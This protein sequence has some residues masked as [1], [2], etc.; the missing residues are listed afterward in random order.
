MSSMPV[1]FVGATY[2]LENR[3]ADVQRTVNMYPVP[4]ESGS[5]KAGYFLR[6]L[7]GYEDY[8]SSTASN[9]QVLKGLYVAE[10]SSA[11]YALFNGSLRLINAGVVGT[12]L[13]VL[14][15]GDF[16]VMTSG[17][18]H[19]VLTTGSAAYAYNFSTTVFAQITSANLEPSPTWCAYLAGRYIFGSANGDQFQWSAQDDP[20]TIDALD[21]ATAESSPD[22]LVRGV[23]YREELW[24]FGQRSIEV[25]RASA[26]PDS[27]FERNSGV[28]IDLGL[29]AAGSVSIV[30]NSL[31]WI[32]ADRN[33]GAVVYSASG[34]A[35]TR[36]SNHA[37]E[38]RLASST[39]IYDATAYC[40]QWKGHPF[41]CLNAPGLDTTLVY[42]IRT[43]LWHERADFFNGEVS[44]HRITHHVYSPLNQHIFGGSL[45]SHPTLSNRSV[46]Y[47]ASDDVYTI[48]GDTLCRERTS[49]HYATPQ[50]NRI[51]YERF[52]LDCSV[53][54]I[55]TGDKYAQLSYSDDG[56]YTWSDSLLQ[57]SLGATGERRVMLQWTRLGMARDR[58]W[59]LRCTD[60]VFFDIIN[61]DVQAKGMLA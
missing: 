49:P 42:D 30:D 32:G 25:W 12:P 26:N 51:A 61:A 22:G 8:A 27:A 59:R 31:L 39:A 52:R 29:M 6:S 7:H 44:Q 17:R 40:Y 37:I 54:G 50:L 53:G 13:G 34:Y 58:V 28:S 45:T 23:V 46:F 47:T 21:F 41:Y 24:L 36:I 48:A 15:A 55:V 38:E 4:V 10:G 9:A 33:G 43:G 1:P 2:Q 20:Y 11:V 57:R 19:L 18:T 56:G 3:K 60:D 16:N 14:T 5:G 35:P